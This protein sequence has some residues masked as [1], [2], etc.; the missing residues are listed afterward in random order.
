MHHLRILLV[1]LAGAAA[2]GLIAIGVAFL[3]SFAGPGERALIAFVG[4]A[5]PGAFAGSVL[6][7]SLLL[8]R[9]GGGERF[10]DIAR[11]VLHI[12]ALIV[13]VVGGLAFVII[14]NLEMAA[15]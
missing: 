10:S 12:A 15:R 3:F 5:P 14:H 13:A 8:Y 2:G 4:F 1:G 6:A 7:I 9:R 11:R